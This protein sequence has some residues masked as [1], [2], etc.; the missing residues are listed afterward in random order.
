VISSNSLLLLPLLAAGL[1]SVRQDGLRLA[2][3][4]LAG[5]AVVLLEGPVDAL[6]VGGLL[7]LCLLGTHLLV[8]LRP[9][10]RIGLGILV[11]LEV[12]PLLGYKLVRSGLVEWLAS[13][14]PGLALGMVPPGEADWLP[15][16]GLSVI[17]FQAVSYTVDRWR[18]QL[19]SHGGVHYLVY[20][21]FFPHLAAGPI[22]RAS[23]FLAQLLSPR[24]VSAQ[25]VREGLWRIFCGLT[26]KLLIADVIARAGVNPV[27]SDPGA[28][29]SVEISIA[30]VAYTLQI[31]LD[32]SGYTDVVIGAARLMGLRMPE[33]FDRPYHATSIAEY[34]RRWHM[35]LSAWVSHYVYRPLGGNR[36]VAWKLYRN[37]MISI[38][39]L[40]V[41]HG[42]TPNFLIYGLIHGSAVCLNRWLLRSPGWVQWTESRP[43]IS[44][45]GGWALTF[46]FVVIARILFR[47]PD[48]ASAAEFSLQWLNSERAG[49]PRFGPAFWG[50]LLAGAVVTFAPDRA[51]QATQSLWLRSSSIVQGALFAGVLIAAAALSDGQALHFIYRQF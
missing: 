23:D 15:P 18:D 10:S 37:V 7:A 29:S 48:L 9:A 31:F 24:E 6:I 38:V 3:I 21:G 20:M 46:A 2:L 27:F 39:L 36:V 51:R 34:W 25:D 13:I 35:S 44:N 43:L 1:L 28:F 12:A 45:L 42:L 8:T 32:F 5:I 50:C 33:N 4:A 16:L 30:L 49:L 14:D 19:P 40:A 26:K 11:V 17:T 22:L 41:W 47:T